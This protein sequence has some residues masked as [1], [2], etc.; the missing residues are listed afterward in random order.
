[1]KK[2][3]ISLLAIIA[4]VFAVSSAFTTVERKAAF[5]SAWF[6]VPGTY[7]QENIANFV[8]NVPLS[9]GDAAII[10]PSTLTSDPICAVEHE[11]GAGSSA[12]DLEQADLNQSDPTAFK[13]VVR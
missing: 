13:Y 6:E 9:V 8:G 2:V 1:M 4:V 10:C 7:A 5:D 12:T 11:R 3:S